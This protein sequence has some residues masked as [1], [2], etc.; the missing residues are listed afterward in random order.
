[1]N[2]DSTRV[3]TPL[4]YNEVVVFYPLSNE[5][6]FDLILRLRSDRWY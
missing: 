3:M 2:T 6:F 5:F 1:M 4:L